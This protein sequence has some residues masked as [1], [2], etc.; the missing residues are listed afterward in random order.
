M[1]NFRSI[2]SVTLRYQASEV[3]KF[4]EKSAEVSD[5][6]LKGELKNQFGQ[7]KL[8]ERFVMVWSDQGNTAAS[9]WCCINLYK[10]LM[11]I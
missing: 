10:K 1:Q 7:P 6:L 8:M 2:S 3:Q 9:I 4:K 11:S 5:L